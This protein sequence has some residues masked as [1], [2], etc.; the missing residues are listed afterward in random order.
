VQ[1][2]PR[3]VKLIFT[4]KRCA[5]SLPPAA[6]KSVAAVKHNKT[7]VKFARKE[8]NTADAQRN[9]NFLS[10]SR[11]CATCTNFPLTKKGKRNQAR[12]SGRDSHYHAKTTLRS[13]FNHALK[14]LNCM[15]LLSIVTLRVRKRDFAAYRIH[16]SSI[17]LC[18]HK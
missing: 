7:K 16:H 2:L 6:K 17:C 10:S 13:Q 14:I 18:L 5:A 15:L 1:E 12:Y 4:K 9:N 8:H 11:R 3:Q